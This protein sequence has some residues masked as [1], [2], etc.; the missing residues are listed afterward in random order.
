ML[1]M[2]VPGARRVVPHMAHPIFGVATVHRNFGY[3]D[4]ALEAYREGLRREPEHPP[5]LAAVGFILSQRDRMEEAVEAYKGYIH[6]AEPRDDGTVRH[7]RERIKEL[8][9]MPQ[10]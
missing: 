9:E 1:R 2:R 10:R 6:C 5:A 7:A 4:K 8:G 3:D